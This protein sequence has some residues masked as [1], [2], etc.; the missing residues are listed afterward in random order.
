[1]DCSNQLGSEVTTLEV[2]GDERHSAFVEVH[3]EDDDD[4]VEYI[5]QTIRTDVKKLQLLT[6]VPSCRQAG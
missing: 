5:V 4:E 2:V 1:M 3:G 6:A